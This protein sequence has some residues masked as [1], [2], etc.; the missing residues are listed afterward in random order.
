MQKIAK[1]HINASDAERGEECP[2]TGVCCSTNP[3]NY[4]IFI[5]GTKL[6]LVD[7]N[8]CDKLLLLGEKVPFSMKSS[9]QALL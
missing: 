3:K 2:N 7:D 6:L 4:S 5:L 1:K 9:Q 8:L